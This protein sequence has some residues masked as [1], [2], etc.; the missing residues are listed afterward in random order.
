MTST[1]TQAGTLDHRAMW[2]HIGDW[3]KNAWEANNDKRVPMTIM[4][5]NL[6]L[7]MLI[8]GDAQSH[9]FLFDKIVLKTSL[10]DIYFRPHKGL[11]DGELTF[12]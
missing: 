10:G 12:L 5:N 4:G 2:K 9:F 3:H 1:E 8:G 6:T 11:D 7:N